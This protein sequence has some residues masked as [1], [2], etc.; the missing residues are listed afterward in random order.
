MAEEKA[1]LSREELLYLAKQAGVKV[2]ENFWATRDNTD[3]YILVCCEYDSV[4]AVL[5]NVGIMVF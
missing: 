1:R 3:V 2:P 4:R 5:I